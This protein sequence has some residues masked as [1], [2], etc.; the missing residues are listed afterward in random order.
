MRQKKIRGMK[1][2]CKNMI[3]RIEENTANFPVQF[4]YNYWHMPLPVAQDF[5]SSGNKVKRLCMQTLLDR[6]KHLIQIKPNDG[7]NYQVVVGIN[8]PGLWYSQIIVFKGDSYFKDFFHRNNETQKR[9]PISHTKNIQ[10]KWQLTVPDGM[11]VLG[12][13]ELITDD[14]YNYEGEFWFI[15]ELTGV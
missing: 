3:E 10:T 8:L 11:Q 14:E 15:G 9:I 13:K 6:A 2:K 1:R 5:I 4:H 7:E 12:Y